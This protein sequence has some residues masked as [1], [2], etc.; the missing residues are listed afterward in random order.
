MPRWHYWTPQA[1][2]ALGETALADWE[3]V[4]EFMQRIGL[5][6]TLVEAEELFTNEFLVQ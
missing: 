1:G 2:S 4:A 5:V 3:A 6:D